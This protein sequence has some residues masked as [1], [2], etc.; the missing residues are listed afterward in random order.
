MKKIID[1]RKKSLKSAKEEKENDLTRRY[2]PP[3]FKKKNGNRMPKPKPEIKDMVENLSSNIA[4]S[5][6]TAIEYLK[7][8]KKRK[9]EYIKIKICF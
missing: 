5:Q 7:K 8:A 3:R 6:N 9:D 2:I 1:N 4:D